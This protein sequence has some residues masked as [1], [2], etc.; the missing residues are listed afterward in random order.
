MSG[1][2]A[3]LK[4]VGVT[5]TIVGALDLVIMIV[6][7]VKHVS[8][9]SSFNIFAVVA[10]IYLI[11]GSIRAA[12]VVH[13]IVA[14]MLV[15]FIGMTIVQL[16]IRPI[17]L[18]ITWYKMNPYGHVASYSF[19]LLVIAFLL[20]IFT[21]LSKPEVMAAR[22]EAGFRTGPPVYAYVLSTIALL[23][24]SVA[25]LVVNHG[26]TAN[27]VKKLA[28]KELGEGYSYYID[29]ISWSNAGNMATVIAYTENDIKGIRVSWGTKKDSN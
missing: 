3:I 22:K 25:M 8:Y 26:E 17:Q 21:Q 16:V 29:S 24:F 14:S 20:W 18:T 13:W 7:I 9:S 19:T 27:I 6:S 1:H 23:G 10:G 2:L 12:R 28:T 15:A 11:K 5:L 4:R